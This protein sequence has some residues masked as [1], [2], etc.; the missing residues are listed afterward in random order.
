MGPSRGAAS[1]RA[2]LARFILLSGQPT[3]LRNIQYFRRDGYEKAINGVSRAL[4]G[5]KNRPLFYSLSAPRRVHKDYS[6]RNSAGILHSPPSAKRIPHAFKKVR[7]EHGRW[8]R[9]SARGILAFTFV[10]IIAWVVRRSYV[11]DRVPCSPAVHVRII[12]RHMHS[13]LPSVPCVFVISFVVVVVS[14]CST[15]ALP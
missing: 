8:Q 1:H 10:V 15:Q 11:P 5:P 6:F 9:A 3:L 7:E 13:P 12:V 14:A 4:A 2:Q